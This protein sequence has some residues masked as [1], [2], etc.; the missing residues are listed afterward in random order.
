[1]LKFVYIMEFDEPSLVKIGVSADPCKRVKDVSSKLG[2]KL[3]GSRFYI[4]PMQKDPYSIEGKCHKA[5]KA[6]KLNGYGPKKIYKREIFR[7]DL[8]TA[9]AVLEDVLAGRRAIPE[10]IEV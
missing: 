8:V 5:L 7:C 10:G 9:K 2:V 4:S 6:F 1:M 3:D